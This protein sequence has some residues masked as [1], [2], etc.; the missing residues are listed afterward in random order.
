MDARAMHVY[1]PDTYWAGGISE[2]IKI[3]ALATTYDVELIPHGHSVPANAN[4]SFALP[5]TTTPLIEFLVK[6][7][8]VHQY[9]LATPVSPVGGMIFPPVEP[10]LGM[11]LDAGRIDAQE[12]LG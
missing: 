3:A 4:L 5:V 6:W 12:E 7:N 10:G 8:I 11:E 1:Q 9:F 2:M